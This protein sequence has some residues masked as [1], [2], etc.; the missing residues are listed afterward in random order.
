MIPGIFVNVNSP[1]WLLQHQVCLFI[2]DLPFTVEILI[3]F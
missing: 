3:R 2:D 1:Y